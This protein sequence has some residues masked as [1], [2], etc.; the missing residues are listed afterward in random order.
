V[1]RTLVFKRQPITDADGEAR[2]M[3]PLPEPLIEQL[4]ELWCEALLANLRRHP[5]EGLK[6]AS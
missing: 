1:S 5:I 2:M 4:A 3:P 6:R